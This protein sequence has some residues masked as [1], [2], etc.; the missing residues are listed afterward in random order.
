MQTLPYRTKMELLP[1]YIASGSCPV[2][3]L[4]GLPKQNDVLTKYFCPFFLLR[5]CRWNYS[6]MSNLCVSILLVATLF[7]RCTLQGH[8]IQKTTKTRKT[9]KKIMK[10]RKTL[11]MTRIQIPSTWMGQPN[12]PEQVIAFQPFKIFRSFP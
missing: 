6:H 10:G 11:T 8:M 7:I 9:W 1:Q 5:L 4:A 3:C 12:E 2:I